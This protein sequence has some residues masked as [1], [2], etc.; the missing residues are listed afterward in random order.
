MDR[1]ERLVVKLAALVAGLSVAGCS[2]GAGPGGG[3]MPDP[4]VLVPR[5]ADPASV[6]R[7]LGFLAKGDPVPFVASFHFLAG[8]SPDSTLAVFSMSMASNALSFRRVSGALEG[9]YRVEVVFRRGTDIVRQFG[10]E[11]TVRVGTMGETRRADESVIFQQFVFLPPGELTVTVVVRDRHGLKSA[12]DDG[13]LEVP[14]FDSSRPML[15]SLIP[16]YQGR[17]RVSRHDLPTILTNPRATSPQGVDTLIF[18]LE[19]YGV[20]P[21][22]PVAVRARHSDGGEAWRDSV[23][24][25][26]AEVAVAVLGDTVGPDLVSAILRIPPNQLELGELRFEAA[27]PGSPDTVRTLALVT[28]SEQ[29]A[30]TNLDDVLQL[31]RYFG[32]DDDVRAIQEAAPSERSELWR[33]FWRKTDPDTMTPENE[34]LTA[35]FR[36]VLIANLRFQE[37]S[38]PGW[39]TDRG[40]VYITLGE[41]DRDERYDDIRTGRT[42]I[43][44]TY[45]YAGETVLLYFVNDLSATTFRLTFSSRV[46][47]QRLLNRVRRDQT[48]AGERRPG[49]E[50]KVSPGVSQHP[51]SV[52]GAS[53]G[54]S[55]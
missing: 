21:G 39:L 43:R 51:V 26:P 3:G 31:L 49:S 22:T 18:Y 35:Y 9:R 7:Q 12:R 42:V 15:S 34:A 14:R 10:S 27:L 50:R 47:Y 41:P 44:W 52:R 36:R 1:K 25:E 20:A 8:P 33:E 32:Y 53:S 4:E 17:P 29:W 40:Q 2:V 37:E 30:V 23:I 5:L 24:L 55:N 13:L 6:Y 46:E 54:L 16:I 48:A 11:Q 38:R 28:F 19:G 45:Y